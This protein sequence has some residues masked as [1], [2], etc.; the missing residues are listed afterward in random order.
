MKRHTLLQYLYLC[1][2][3]LFTLNNS[4]CGCGNK[5]LDE[6][7]D[8]EL[9][10]IELNKSQPKPLGAVN[11]RPVIEVEGKITKNLV[12]EDAE[13]FLLVIPKGLSPEQVKSIV[14]S[15][16]QEKKNATFEKKPDAAF[17][18]STGSNK[19]LAYFLRDVG[20]KEEA[21]IKAKIPL[22]DLEPGDYELCLLLNYTNY[23]TAFSN[24]E[25]FKALS[26][27]A[28]GGTQP[29]VRLNKAETGRPP[30]LVENK[31]MNHI[32]CTAEIDTKPTTIQNTWFLFIKKQQDKPLTATEILT[33]YLKDDT[34][35]LPDNENLNSIADN[36]A[37]VTKST[38]NT[39]NSF[40][41]VKKYN[42]DD[43]SQPFERGVT[44]AVYA[45]MMYKED[46]KPQY[47]VSE[48]MDMTTP[49][50]IVTL[51]MNKIAIESIFQSVDP[52]AARGVAPEQLTINYEAE[53]TKNEGTTHSAMGLLF[54]ENNASLTQPEAQTKV[55]AL[56]KAAPTEGYHKHTND[57]LYMLSAG[58]HTDGIT[59]TVA[60]IITTTHIPLELG[61]TYYVYAF[62]QDTAPTG[63]VFL[64]GNSVKL[65]VPKQ[66]FEEAEFKPSFEWGEYNFMHKLKLKATPIDIRAGFITHGAID[67]MSTKAAHPM[68]V[69]ILAEINNTK[70]KKNPLQH[71]I[72]NNLYFEMS[73]KQT[74]KS[75]LYPLGSSDKSQPQLSM[76]AVCA[77]T[78]FVF[79]KSI[80]ST[81]YYKHDDPA[82]EIAFTPKPVPRIPKD[83]LYYY[84]FHHSSRP[85]RHSFYR[86]LK[87][88]APEVKAVLIPKE[89]LYADVEKLDGKT[90]GEYLCDLLN[91]GSPEEKAALYKTFMLDY[92]VVDSQ[93]IVDLK[94]YVIKEK[95]VVFQKTKEEVN[96]LFEHVKS[97]EPDIEKLYE[98]A[99]YAAIVANIP[100]YYTREKTDQ[101]KEN[102]IKTLRK[103]L[104][105]DL[106][107]PENIRNAIPDAAQIQV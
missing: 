99:V 58:H 30:I 53:I 40:K 17:P 36:K 8:P 44:Y 14:A 57:I 51:A 16:R 72:S 21:D 54:V 49:S 13:A 82:G 70:E 46:G 18:I 86:K 43:T 42:Q 100:E 59:G 28:P 91:D 75:K 69:A 4:G 94:I 97:T 7:I 71:K 10:G 9:T 45:V 88:A 90:L 96:T 11:G 64:S 1:L 38:S 3:L 79:W 52:R 5:V 101:Y 74:I 102:E 34:K 106:F 89:T 104:K 33:A 63:E 93:E 67:F 83:I 37:I 73:P 77:G 15:F 56:R 92:A 55:A 6:E 27:Q 60:N 31:I 65:E 84:T 81:Y 22:T 80:A 39:T 107:L 68:L 105:K 29:A 26:I 48:P 32:A 25:S 19:I 62:V 2:V 95:T 47:V 24:I 78:N 98:R 35:V 61:K 41:T 23:G 12:G 103:A 66:E 76:K 50:A 87:T 20:R 85:Y